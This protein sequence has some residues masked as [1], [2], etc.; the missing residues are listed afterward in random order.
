MA[1]A[2]GVQRFVVG[3]RFAVEGRVD[4]AF[5]PGNNIPMNSE[6]KACLP[7][8]WTSAAESDDADVVDFAPIAVG[9]SGA[10]VH[11]VTTRHG[12]FVLKRTSV[13]EP[14][15]TWT[16]AVAVQRAAAEVGAAPQVVHHDAERRA[17]LSELIAG[18]IP[19]AAR[20]GN[21][22][23]RA[24]AL[25]QFAGTIRRVHDL[26][27]EGPL[28]AMPR[29]DPQAVLRTVHH[30]AHDIGALPAWV[31]AH[32][33]A[34]LEEAPPLTD[35]APVLSHND[36]N[37]TNI[38]CAGDRLVL[39]D[40]QSAA[41]NDPYYDLATAAVFLRMDADA[42][43]A[44]LWAY[45]Q[46]TDRQ[47]IESVD[48]STIAMLPPRFVWS[49]RI[50]AALSGT[51][52]LQMAHHRGHRGDT[53]SREDDALLLEQVYAQMRA[54]TVH[55]HTGEGQWTLGLA[56]LRASRNAR[57]AQDVRNT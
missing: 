26:P 45:D 44:L 47:D 8:E 25:A 3:T 32:V 28:H 34:L 52:F 40:W 50:A 38:A 57:H 7:P 9:Q 49:Q 21:P 55:L 6:L 36:V 53:T 24:A 4:T 13:Q 27:L 23:T 31:H 43:A 56:L 46:A 19:F 35:R 5:Y 30:A 10:S 18:D 20:Y 33:H 17:V 42:S 1:A 29:A 51:L 12:A 37:P 41:I 39:L 48:R 14:L 2:R 22:A 54:G 11:R 16:L 15:A